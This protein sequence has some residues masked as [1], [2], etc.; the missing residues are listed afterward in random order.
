MRAVVMTGFVKNW[1]FAGLFVKW[2][3]T[4]PYPNRPPELQNPCFRGTPQ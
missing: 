4:T 1:S 2:P 3:P